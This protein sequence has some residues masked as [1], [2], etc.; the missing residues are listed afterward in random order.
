M[1]SDANLI[2]VE[3]KQMPLKIVNTAFTV[4]RIKN[5]LFVILKSEDTT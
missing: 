4:C 1:T 3:D 2:F 5:N